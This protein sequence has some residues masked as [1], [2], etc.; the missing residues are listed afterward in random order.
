MSK[1]SIIAAGAGAL[2]MLAGV[3]FYEA[4]VYHDRMAPPSSTPV[5]RA[6]GPFSV[7]P[8]WIKSGTPN[9]RG[10]ETSRSPDGSGVTGLWACDGPSTFEWHFATDETVHLLEGKVEVQYL[11]RRFTL[12]AGDTATFHFGTR[13]VWHVPQ[14]AKKVFVLHQPGRL[15]RLWRK[16]FPTTT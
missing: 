3:A 12:N 8:S 2:L 10:T 15:V 1:K 14:H 9:F 5:A 6:L 7:D 16:V 11:G 4:A 13:A